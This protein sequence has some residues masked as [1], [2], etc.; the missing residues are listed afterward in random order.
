MFETIETSLE[1]GILTV[2]LNR[3]DVLNSYTYKMSEELE[4]LFQNV[5]NDDSVRVI[6]VTGKGRA[7]CA[8]MDLSEGEDSFKVDVS[9]EEFRDIGG[10]VSL[11]IYELNK[12]II[13][14]INGPAVGIGLTMTLPMDIR[15][16]KKD[17]KVGF[18]FARRGIGPEACSGWFLTKHVGIGK[19]LEWMYTGRYIST[20]EGLEAGLFQYEVEDPLQKAQEIAQDIINYTAATSIAFTRELLWKMVNA[21]HPSA[22]HKPES[23]FLFWAS[24]HEDAHE[25]VQSFMEKRRPEFSLKASDLPSFFK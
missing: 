23:Q 10:K 13:A 8:G 11:K 6:I 7:F 2:T 3:P 21:P 24:R 18:V 19:A 9:A 4:Q 1:Q 15:I 16:V 25:G 12:P 22:S 14:A 20:K 5:K 17:T